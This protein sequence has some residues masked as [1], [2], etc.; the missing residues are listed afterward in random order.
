MITINVRRMIATLGLALFAAS[1]GC[2]E[3]GGDG[4]GNGEGSCNVSSDCDSGMVCVSY[5]AAGGV[6]TPQCSASA[7]DCGGE[8]SCSG[9]GAVEVNIC[10][11]DPADPQ[12]PPDAENQPQIR[13]EVDADCAALQEGTICVEW[14]GAKACT[15]PCGVEEDCDLPATGG[16]VIDLL[17]CLDDEA[18]TSRKGCV[19][20]EKCFSDIQSCVKAPGL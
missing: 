11:D 20:D 8:G 14:K 6:C 3:G 5:G 12:S 1:M 13:C 7:D 19:P 2:T 18:D 4:G 17:T 15:I 16:V 9:V 10:Q